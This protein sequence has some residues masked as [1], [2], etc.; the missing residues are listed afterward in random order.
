MMDI[1]A[2]FRWSPNSAQLAN[3][4]R[5]G[6]TGAQLNVAAKSAAKV[7]A[8]ALVEYERR[9]DA[10]LAETQQVSASKWGT[11]H[12]GGVPKPRLIGAHG[13]LAAVRAKSPHL[14]GGTK[15]PTPKLDAFRAKHGHLFGDAPTASKTPRREP[16]RSL[17][18]RAALA[19]VRLHEARI[20]ERE[21]ADKA[22]R[23]DDALAKSLEP[24]PKVWLLDVEPCRYVGGEVHE[25][26]QTWGDGD[27]IWTT[28]TLTVFGEQALMEGRYP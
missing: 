15:V 28:R 12:H 10:L 24:P 4:R 25:I 22:R 11:D 8:R 3:Y 5:P 23:A 14:F 2:P 13:K 19:K 18:S 6:M 1:P 27:R 17:A 16:P 21:A 9:I 20:A 26:E 7:R